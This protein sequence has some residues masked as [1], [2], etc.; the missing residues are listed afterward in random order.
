MPRHTALMIGFTTEPNPPS[1][2]W[3]AAP[4]A[5]ASYRRRFGRGGE[6]GNPPVVK[7]SARRLP[8]CPG[9]CCGWPAVGASSRRPIGTLR[10]A[11]IG[12][13]RSSGTSSQFMFMSCPS[14]HVESSGSETGS[15][16]SEMPR[17]SCSPQTPPCWWTFVASTHP[18]PEG[19]VSSALPV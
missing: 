6:S 5:F 2:S 8:N 15:S 9:G 12:G 17:S 18:N 13:V 3:A 4:C 7:E 14:S 16:V 19:R 10:E 1:L 11:V